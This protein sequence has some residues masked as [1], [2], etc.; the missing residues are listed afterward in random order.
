[1]LDW[2]IQHDQELLL[3]LNQFH[4]PTMDWLM[5]QLTGKLI[6]VPL[7]AYF[8]YLLWKQEKQEVWIAVLLV[9]ATVVASDLIAS[10]LFKPWIGRLRPCWEP[11]LEGLLFQSEHYRCGGKFGFFSSH[12]SISFGLA[13]IMYILTRNKVLGISLWIW[14]SM[15]SYTR[16]Y[17]VV[18][19]PLDVLAGALCGILMGILFGWAFIQIKKTKAN[20]IGS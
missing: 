7:Y 13:T 10:A 16:V 1:M 5:I 9:V 18:H 4:T 19:Y 15:V 3:W 20:S 6:W 2:I 14:A 17:L 11:T 8:L 12:A